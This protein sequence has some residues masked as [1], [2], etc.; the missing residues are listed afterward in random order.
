[1]E[2][3]SRFDDIGYRQSVPIEAGNVCSVLDLCLPDSVLQSSACI[4]VRRDL[5]THPEK[6]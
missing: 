4:G 2:L 1:M 5:N 3:L 6:E